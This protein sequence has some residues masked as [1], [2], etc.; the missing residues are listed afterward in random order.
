VRLRV[1]TKDFADLASDNP[2]TKYR[3][4]KHLLAVA[5]EHPEQLYPHRQVFTRLLK[6]ENTILKWMAIDIIGCLSSAGK[7]TRV[8]TL[9]KSLSGFLH[10]GK[11][12]TANHAIGALARVALAKPAYR[13]RVTAELLTVEHSSYETEEC[14]NIAL[15]KVIEALGLYCTAAGDNKRVMNFVSRQTTNGRPATRKKAEKFLSNLGRP[16]H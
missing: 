6:G 13:D 16:T 11:L 14:R 5:K 2:G 9:L 10:G 4:A 15:G 12:I 3:R 7:N 1:T 8:D